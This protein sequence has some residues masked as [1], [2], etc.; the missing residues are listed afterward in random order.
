MIRTL[1]LIAMS[2]TTPSTSLAQ[3]TTPV[4]MYTEQAG[5]PAL[6][7]EGASH[8][9]RLAL[10]CI[11]K[12]YPNKLNQVLTDSERLLSPRVLHP[13]FYGCLDWHSSVHGH[14]MLVKL[15]KEF[16]GLPE[17]D[18][19]LARLEQ[20]LTA[21]NIAAEVRYFDHE[22]D[23]WERTYGWAWL[24]Q[25]AL[26]LH[27][28]REPAGRELGNHLAPLVALIRSRYMNFLPR[29]DYPIRTGVHPNT[30]FG[31]SFALDYARVLEDSDFEAALIAAARQYYEHD[32][33]CPLS[34]E[35]GGEDFLSPCLEEA[36][37]M[38]RVLP[39]KAYRRWLQGFLPQLFEDGALVPARVGDRSD[40]KIVHLDGLNLSRA[41]DLYIIASALTDPEKISRLRQL[42]VRHLDASLPFVASEHYEGSHWLGSFAVYALTRE[43]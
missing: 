29:Q 30:A 7:V 16:P 12:E 1:L 20:S 23:S 21:D 35:P 27:T 18:E 42:A 41:W 28:W 2:L 36:A 38:A 6:T 26:E 4:E 34:W 9:A 22:W 11:P 10:D 5:V 3:E 37:L 25:L 39:Q 24:L 33:D 15:L 14:W 31:L 40:P 19:I 17:R 32:A 43:R 8:F 13:A